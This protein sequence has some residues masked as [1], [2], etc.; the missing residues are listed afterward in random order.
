MLQRPEFKSRVQVFDY[1][2]LRIA[3]AF[4]REGGKPMNWATFRIS[5]RENFQLFTKDMRAE[6]PPSKSGRALLLDHGNH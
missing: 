6:A 3:C 4:P 5:N 2:D 1:N